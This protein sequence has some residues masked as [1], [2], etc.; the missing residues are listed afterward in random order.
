MELFEKERWQWKKKK[1]EKKNPQKVKSKTEKKC[2][3][4]SLRVYLHINA[5]SGNYHMNELLLVEIFAT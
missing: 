2:C 3:Q 4:K 1:I 5:E